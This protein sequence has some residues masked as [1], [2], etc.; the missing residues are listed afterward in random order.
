M[1]N[2]V[3]IVYGTRPEFLKVYPLILEAKRRGIDVLTINTGQHS[4]ILSDMEGIFEF[5]PNYKLKV[6]NVHFSNAELL[7]KL[8]EK[9]DQIIKLEEIDIV[10]AQGDTFTVL[11]AAMISFLSKKKFYHVEAGLRTDNIH[12]PFPEEFNRRVVTLVSRMNFAPTELSKAN[13]LKEHIGGDKILV[14]GNTIIDLLC[15]VIDRYHITIERSNVVFV[16]AHRREN[17][18]Q[19]LNEICETIQELA[20]ENPN[21]N[22]YWSLHPNPEVRKMVFASLNKNQS[23]IIFLEPL[24]YVE[25]VRLMARSL[26]LISDSGGIQ[27]EAPT[28]NKRIL[29]LR[30]ETERP[31]VLECGSGVLVGSERSKIKFEFYKEL[32]N[33][34]QNHKFNN[35]FGDGNA[36]SLIFD[37]LASN[38]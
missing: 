33:V 10:V 13:L 14:T 23:N 27:E 24:D 30:Q 4:D 7:A 28:L 11:A 35:P 12:L 9:V 34:D 22:F 37:T 38:E 36:A 25:T 16:T 21:I 15:Y 5:T 29:I 3:A 26:L 31:E 17:I 1:K 32:N 19:R 8:I 6:Q 18:G 2:K 20:V